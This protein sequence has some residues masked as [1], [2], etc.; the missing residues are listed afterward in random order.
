MS[1]GKF[2]TLEGGEGAGKS[3]QVGL[4]GE[5]L[6][7]S[8]LDVVVTRE[9]GGA[10][11][12]EEI[13]KLLVDGGT[14]RWTPMG[15]ALLHSAA[16][17]DHLEHTVRPA[18]D[19]GSWVVSDRFADSTVAYQGY[20]HRLGSETIIDLN[21]LV[22][23]DFEPDLTVVLDLPVDEGLARASARGT[24]EDRYERMGADFHQRLRDGFLEIAEREPGRCAV[25]DGVGE[26]E[27]VQARIRAVVGARL[28]VEFR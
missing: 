2:I 23:G 14:D 16:R 18:L 13:R 12:A 15:E 1:E 27:D 17:I 22:I 9:P 19:A 4:L 25:V 10:P 6:R 24:A 28:G 21:R 5:A 3:T 7:T 26:V 11:G 8:G 20:G